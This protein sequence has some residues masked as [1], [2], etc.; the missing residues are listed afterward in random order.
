MNTTASILKL[1]FIDIETVSEKPE[2]KELPAEWQELWKHKISKTMPETM[3]GEDSY[4]LKAGIFAE[5][6]KIICISL[7]FLTENPYKELE[8][9]VKSICGDDEK[10]LLLEFIEVVDK[11]YKRNKNFEFAGH[12]IREFDIPY[13]C[14]RMLIGNIKL[15]DYLNF[16]GVKP[17]HVAMTDTLQWWKFGD[18]KNYI[19]L[20]LLAHVLN[21]PTSKT[22]I[23]GSKVQYVYYHEKDLARIV[24]YCQRDVIVVA[25][26]ILRFKNLPLLKEENIIVVK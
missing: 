24:D 25:N 23:D 8:L 17:W 1:L 16:Q 12:N 10:K 4:P 3:P 5:F 22:D 2:Y 26:V 14:R 20:N 15:P 21:I 19:S 9:K 18:Y 7:G 6:G 13:I 11:V